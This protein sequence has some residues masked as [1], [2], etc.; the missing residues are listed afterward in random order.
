MNSINKQGSR[1]S[2]RNSDE[3]RYVVNPA[4]NLIRANP[5]TVVINLGSRSPTSRQLTDSGRRG[6]LA[7]LLERWSVPVT[8]D[9]GRHL[10]DADDDAV[11]ELVKFLLQEKVLIPVPEMESHAFLYAM[12]LESGRIKASSIGVI[13]AGKLCTPII[14]QLLDAGVGE[15]WLCS[16]GVPAMKDERVVR[17][18]TDPHESHSLDR[19]AS[20]TDLVLCAAD[21]I[22]LEMLF[23]INSVMIQ[24]GKKPWIPVIV[25]GAEIQVGPVLGTDSGPCY[26][27]LDAQ[28]EASR[29]QLIS[30]LA[31][32]SAV[33]G[34]AGFIKRSL[35]QVVSDMVAA[36]ATLS[37]LHIVAGMS[38][39]L[40]DY[41][42]R[43]D[44]ERFEVI[45]DRILC[46]PRCPACQAGVAD[47]RHPFL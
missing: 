17:V 29:T 38:S 34:A 31:H 45:R 47:Y 14:M 20:E 35:P 37:A 15:I 36:W 16:D 6:I 23:R 42:V 9:Q 10:V 11:D 22:D 44:L 3:E 18:G 2:V 41:R 19:I 27:C 7:D 5:N 13:G 12:G 8:L 4:F 39:F 24:S 46:L 28:D 43:I 26:N 40:S 1:S 25:D 33:L 30:F 21:T 32:K